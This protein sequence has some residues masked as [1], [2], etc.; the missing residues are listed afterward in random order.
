MVAEGVG[1]A[2]CLDIVWKKYQFF[3]KPARL[4]WENLQKELSTD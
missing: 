1:Y 3:S 2:L 4:F